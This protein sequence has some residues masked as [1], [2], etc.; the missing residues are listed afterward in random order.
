MW[1][2][3]GCEGLKDEREHSPKKTHE[4]FGRNKDVEVPVCTG[5]RDI[6]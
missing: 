1:S 4:V 6:D 3:K 2:K 5:K